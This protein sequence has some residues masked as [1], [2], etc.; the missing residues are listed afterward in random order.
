MITA[1]YPGTF[2]P[3]TRGHED[4]VRRAASLFDQVVVGPVAVKTPQRHRYKLRPRSLHRTDHDIGGGKF[5]CA[6]QQARGKD[7]P[8]KKEWIVFH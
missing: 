3:L 4:L 2:D 6:D 8:A 7:A 5:A 1:I